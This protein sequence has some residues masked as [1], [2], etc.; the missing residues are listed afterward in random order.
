MMRDILICNYPL[1]PD[2]MV[3][4]SAEI[5]SPEHICFLT[6]QSA[7]SATR[8]GGFG[9][10]SL[11]RYHPLL[12]K[13]VGNFCS[14]KTKRNLRGGVIYSINGC[15]KYYSTVE[16][17]FIDSSFAP[18]H[19]EPSGALALSPYSREEDDILLHINQLKTEYDYFNK[20]LEMIQDASARVE[21]SLPHGILILT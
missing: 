5:G 3:D 21:V 18:F 12:G 1:K 13:Q 2:F 20:R 8:N 10:Q 11:T 14:T 6:R 7:T 19:L 16:K 9:S 15:V 4:W 17:Y